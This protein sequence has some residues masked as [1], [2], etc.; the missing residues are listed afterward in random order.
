MFSNYKA[1]WVGLGAFALFLI[2]F[3]IFVSA[4]WPGSND[5]CT[6]STP[7]TCFCESYDVSQAIGV[8][9][10]ANT[11][12]NLG[13]VVAGLLILWQLGRDRARGTIASN[14][15]IGPR[16]MSI[17]YGALVLFLG[18]ASMLFHGSLKAWGGW[19][20]GFS[21]VLFGS[22][23]FLYDFADV[24]NLSTLLFGI[25]FL[26]FTIPIGVLGALF[27]D[28]TILSL[29]IGT[30]FFGVYVVSFLVL[31]IMVIL[32]VTHVHRQPTP[33]WW[34]A[35]GSFGLAFFGFWLFSNTGGPLCNLVGRDS[36]L[37]GHAAWQLTSAVTTFALFLYFRTEGLHA[38]YSDDIHLPI[39]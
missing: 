37:Q 18:P 19:F 38:K 35:L 22:F 2:I 11:W 34:I 10:P 12:S 4:G 36:L 6:N 30:F 15:M 9:Q 25:L 28:T 29:A 23:L 27:G 16:L 32:R 5:S 14:L 3:A 8:R 33:W 26:V 1:F 13:Y 7:D 20:D 24:L 17:G 31:D 21:L 39:G